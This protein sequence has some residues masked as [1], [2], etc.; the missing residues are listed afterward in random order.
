MMNKLSLIIKLLRPKH[1]LKN[2]IIFLPIL[3]S[4][5]ITKLNLF[6]QETVIFV[7]FCLIASAVYVFNDIFDLENDKKHPTKS[8]RPIASG[9]ISKGLAVFLY[10]LLIIISLLMAL[11]LNLSS[12]TIVLA[13]LILNI[14]YT[15]KLK[16]IPLLDVMCIALGFIFRILA[17]CF[18]IGVPPSPLVILMTF[19][20]SMFFT[21]SKRKMEIKLI[22]NKDELRNSIK[23]FDLDLVNQF[24]QMN[25]VLSIAFYFTYVIDE[26]TI[27]RAGTEYLYLT[28][29]PFTLLIFR[30]LW[31]LNNTSSESP[32]SFFEKDIVIKLMFVFYLSTLGLVLAL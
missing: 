1:Y 4:L 15:I 16:E 5:N 32:M 28:V 22:Q 27:T 13:Y 8:T 19:F 29:I 2:I 7:S 9:E 24:V 25:A 10:I 20:V 26:Q 14:F 30:I 18:A 6:L 3:F 21:F 17:G 23:N 31:L 11:K 12:F